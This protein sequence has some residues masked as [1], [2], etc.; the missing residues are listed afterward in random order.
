MIYLFFYWSY[1]T[2][3][4]NLLVGV[5]A[6][7]F[8][9]AFFLKLWVS[10]GKNLKRFHCIEFCEE[11]FNNLKYYSRRNQLGG[12]LSLAMGIYIISCFWKNV[13]SSR[14]LRVF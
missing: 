5:G 13:A 2:C 8:E 6:F 4:D 12:L 7:N 9:M 14:R 11:S 1:I 3:F 10:L